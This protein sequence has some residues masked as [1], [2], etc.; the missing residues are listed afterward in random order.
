MTE[1]DEHDE[2]DE[3]R[4][5]LQAAD[6]AS[7]LAA[8][9][10]TW[11]AQLLED[12]MADELTDESRADGTHHRS[13]LTW[14]VAAAAAVLMATGVTFALMEE[15]D[16][17]PQ[18]AGDQP[19]PAISQT[20]TDLTVRGDAAAAK[21]LVPSSAP[22]VVTA[23]TLVFDGTVESIS[24]D[25]V[26]LRPSTFYTGEETDL[27]TVQAPSED[28]QFLLSAVTFREGERYLVAATDGRV[29]LCGF[30]DVYSDELAA[31][32]EDAFSG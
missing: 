4:N 7:S 23:Q 24:G 5:Q 28:M 19:A 29:T 15:D 10:P 18:S 6:P 26:T 32:Y 30:S 9:D 16:N 12:T 14:L 17:A 27:V 20:V 21:C 1:H 11:V 2:H 22:Q 31:V 13:K 25:S 8:A 3:L